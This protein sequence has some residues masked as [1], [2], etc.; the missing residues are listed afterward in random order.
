MRALISLILS[1]IM[2]HLSVR[3]IKQKDLGETS[4]FPEEN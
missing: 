2:L 1:T 4:M 3:A